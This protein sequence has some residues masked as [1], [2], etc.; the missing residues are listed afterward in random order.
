M[1]EP[2]LAFSGFAVGDL[3]A[4]ETFY[5]DVLGMRVLRFPMGVL[6]I[7]INRQTTVMAYPKPDHTPAGYTMLNLPVDDLDKAVDELAAQGVEFL[8][9]DGFDHDERGIVRSGEHGGPDIAWFTDPSGNVIA[10]LHG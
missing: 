6:G 1:S 2:N 7:R 5:R 10:V 3:E 4:A 8:R 9:Y